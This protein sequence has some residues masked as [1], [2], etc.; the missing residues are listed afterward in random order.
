[1]G[2]GF[3]DTRSSSISVGSALDVVMPLSLERVLRGFPK[4]YLTI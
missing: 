4:R 1:M 2:E 3:R